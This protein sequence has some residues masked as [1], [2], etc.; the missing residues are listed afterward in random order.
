MADQN[1]S[2]PQLK[3]TETAFLRLQDIIGYAFADPALLERALTHPSYTVEDDSDNERMEFLGDSVLNLCVG[4][5][6][7]ERFPKWSEGRLTQVKSVLV[8]TVTLARVAETL[9]LRRLS[10]LGKGLP[11]DEA[12]PPSVNANL[13]EAICGAVYLDGGME[14]ARNFILRVMDEEIRSI[15]RNGH[16]PNYKSA[17][18]QLAQRDLGQ[19]PHYRVV[20]TTGPDH[21]KTFEVVAMI[22]ARSFPSATGRSKKEAEQSAAKSALEVLA[23]EEC[24]RACSQFDGTSKC[25]QV[26]SALSAENTE[27]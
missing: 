27:A 5:S 4:Q 1:S 11:S 24:V 6:L 16:E 17:L 20:S 18:Q 22:G 25:R 9:C 21:G 7:Y 26:E 2:V 3:T 13:F 19:T 14:S 23:G 8:S 15:S 10:R 12:L